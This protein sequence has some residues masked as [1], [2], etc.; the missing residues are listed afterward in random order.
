MEKLNESFLTPEQELRREQEKLAENMQ[1]MSDELAHFDEGAEIKLPL[2]MQVTEALQGLQDWLSKN[3]HENAV[4]IALAT[5]SMLGTMVTSYPLAQQVETPEKLLFALGVG[6][7]TLVSGK[8]FLS[9]MRKLANLLVPS[10]KE[11][12]Q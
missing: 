1:T 8:T 11:T 3:R 5:G 2:S 7:A 9:G 4:A 12:S 6:T 10:S